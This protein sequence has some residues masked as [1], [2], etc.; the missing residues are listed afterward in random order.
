MAAAVAVAPVEKQRATRGPGRAKKGAPVTP[1]KSAAEEDGRSWGWCS[2]DYGC[3]HE[4]P[5]DPATG[6]IV[7]HNAFAQSGARF[8]CGGSGHLPGD[9]PEPDTTAE[10]AVLAYQAAG[11]GSAQTL[12][13]G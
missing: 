9:A 6:N 10:I 3:G 11:Q 7:V 4:R 13:S 8:I 2:A 1:P 12:W 5:I